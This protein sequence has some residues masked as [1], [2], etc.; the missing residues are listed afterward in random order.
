[1]VAK[2]SG[3]V[4]KIF[5]DKSL[6]GKLTDKINAG[7]WAED[8]MLLSFCDKSKICC[9]NFARKLPTDFR[10]L[11]KLAALEPKISF[12]DLPGQVGGRLNRCLS[13]NTSKDMVSI[14]WSLAS[15]EAWPWSPV[16]GDRAR[17]NVIL[18]GV[19]G[20]K[21]DVLA[22]LR[23]E[24]DPIHAAFSCQNPH[25]IL[26][27][28]STPKNEGDNTIDSCV[29]E[30]YKNGVKRVSATSISLQAAVSCVAWNNAEDKL[31][32]GCKDKSLVVYD[33][34]RLVTQRR[35]IPFVPSE[36][37][38]H[39]AGSV[40]FIFSLQG[41]IQVFDMALA[42]V[43]LQLAGE[44]QNESRIFRMS[45]YFRDIKLSHA[46]WSCDSP[47]NY[48]SDGDVACSDNMFM[49][50]QDGGLLCNFRIELGSL[51]LGRIGPREIIEE[52]IKHNQAEQAVNFVNSINW[53]DDGSSCFAC[54]SAV[55]N[56]LLKFPLTDK[57]EGLLEETLG[58]FYTPSRPINDVVVLQYREPL[59]RWSRRFFY[60]LLRYKKFQKAFM[61]AV[62]I[63]AADLFMDIHF[64]ALDAGN[65]ALAENAKNKAL[66]IDSE[67]LSTET[68]S[69]SGVE[70]DD[71]ISI[72][73]EN[74]RVENGSL[75]RAGLNILANQ[76]ENGNNTHDFVEQNAVTGQSEVA[77]VNGEAEL[78]ENQQNSAMVLPLNTNITQNPNVWVRANILA[79]QYEDGNTTQ[80]FVE[81]NATTGQSEVAEV[82]GEAELPENQQNS[83]TVL[84]LNTNITQDPDVWARANNIELE[85]TENDGEE[86]IYL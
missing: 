3:D 72:E 68:D 17:A 24:C 27:I 31:L 28:E 61:L 60:H 6:C 1:M 50:F 65:I 54:L 55:M 49:V 26:T 56:Y 78:P 2:N 44:D 19:K 47:L 5:I 66:E 59:S 25:H 20:G 13:L 32:L 70:D 16:A 34:H 85:T 45:E 53:N 64:V 83:T 71:C 12:I 75:N 58:C 46:V 38:W 40:V 37:T 48:V 18:I 79:N 42:P 35:N 4:E 30:F 15:E 52:Y 77:E 62:D 23:T 8:F 11:E 14:W 51:T 36:I 63:G 67:L 84:P 43:L 39:P 76:F 81:Q 74:N 82:N 69:S 33:C 21:F 86:V 41:D 9:I 80:D 7:V 57:R 73:E 29:Y 22:Y 10:K